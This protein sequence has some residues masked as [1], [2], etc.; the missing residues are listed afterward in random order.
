MAEISIVYGIMAMLGFGLSNFF[1]L[2][3]V[4][5]ESALTVVFWS[6]VFG[7]LLLVLFVGFSKALPNSLML[8]TILAVAGVVGAVAYLSFVRGLKVDRLSIVAPL[9]NSWSLITVLL[10]VIFLSQKLTNSQPIGVATVI[11]GTVLVSL[12]LSDIKKLHLGELEGGAKYGLAAM[13]GWGIQ[14]FLIAELA[15]A[16]GWFLPI[17]GITVIN[18]IIF[19]VL[20]KTKKSNIFPASRSMALIILSGILNSGAFLAYGFGVTFGK[21]AIVAPLAASG[22]FVAVLLALILLREKVRKE[23][24]LGIALIMAGIILLSL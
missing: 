8:L 14:S 12:K 20:L 15:P 7:I 4:K 24:G 18:A 13:L 17:F 23:Q 21:S 16:L 5:K 10:S 11:A 2:L 19:F 9:G 6:E 3:A 1:A 22:T